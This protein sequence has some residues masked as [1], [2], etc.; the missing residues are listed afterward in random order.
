MRGESSLPVVA[1]IFIVAVLVFLA[2]IPNQVSP[3]R[4][5]APKKV[6]IAHLKQIQGAIEQWASEN[7]LKATN[8]VTIADISGSPKNLIKPL[9]NKELKCPAGGIYSIT[10]VGEV[11]RC[12]VRGHTL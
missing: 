10:L 4:N 3:P 2:A 12:S 8:R 6:C 5:R 11:P 1:A 9:I 7:R